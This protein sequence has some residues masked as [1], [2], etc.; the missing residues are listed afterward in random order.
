MPVIEKYV[1]ICTRTPNLHNMYFQRAIEQEVIAMSKAYPVVTITGPRQSGKTT[2]AKHLFGKLPYHSFENP[3]TRLLAESDPRGFLN[4]FDKGAV[5]DEIQHVPLLLSYLQQMVD[6]RKKELLFILTGSNQ[7]SL[8]NTISQ[9]LA[10]RT[11][12]L[13][14]LPLSLEEIRSVKQLPTDEIMYRGFYPAIHADGLNPTKAYR[15]YYE[16]YLER[17]MRQIIQIRELSLFQ[18]FIRICA[19][20]TANLYNASAMAAETG[21]SVKT[22]QSWTSILEASYVIMRLQPYHENIKK[23]LIKSPKL[24]FY[25]VGLATY[26]LG[27]E[28]TQQ[29]IRDPLR[30][31]LFENMVIMEFVKRRLNQ[32]LDPNLFFYRDSHHFEID[33][34]QKKGND[35]VPY[36]IKSAQTFHPGFLNGLNRFKKLFTIR[37]PEM[38]LI[39]DGEQQTS[40]RDVHLLNFRNL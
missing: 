4:Q 9:S 40:I 12:I 31:A 20:R 36:E 22:I 16:T 32:G 11:A 7:F 23:R 39:Y 14:L 19:G 3:D 8:L 17:D 34:I 24:Y 5:L 29:L 18:K 28:E 26:L 38:F 6:E 2:L 25:D 37:V 27:I 1:Y 13:K 30:G 15:N 21:V 33:L 35:L 10:G